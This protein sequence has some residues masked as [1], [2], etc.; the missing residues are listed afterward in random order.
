M[1]YIVPIDS[2]KHILIQTEVNKMKFIRKKLNELKLLFCWRRVLYWREKSKSYEKNALNP[3]YSRVLYIDQ[4]LTS[5]GNRATV[6][7]NK[8]RYSDMY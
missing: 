2:N 1:C 7:L 4:K 6:L 8:C 5:W 3:S